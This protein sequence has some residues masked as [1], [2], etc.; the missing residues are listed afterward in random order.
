MN[1]P[2]FC[3]DVPELRDGGFFLSPFLFPVS[4]KMLEHNRSFHKCVWWTSEQM[5]AQFVAEYEV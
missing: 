3:C 2:T 5:N 4:L 1:S